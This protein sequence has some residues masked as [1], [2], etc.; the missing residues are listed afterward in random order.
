MEL[1]L[2]LDH[3]HHLCCSQPSRGLC[4]FP[5]LQTDR[6]ILQPPKLVMPANP[7]IV[8]STVEVS[9]VEPLPQTLENSEKFDETSKP[10]LKPLHW[11]KVRASL[12]R[13]MVWDHLRSSSFNLNEEMIET[14]IVVNMPATRM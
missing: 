3:H 6:P 11:N 10:K 1:R 5:C 2:C 12:D 4:K 13:E 14:L 7:F 9:P 8:Q